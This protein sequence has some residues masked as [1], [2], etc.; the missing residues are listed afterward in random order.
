[1]AGSSSTVEATPKSVAGRWKRAAIVAFGVV[2]ASV[3]LVGVMHMPFARG[4]LMRAGGCPV[5]G[6][7]Q[8]TPEVMEPARHAAMAAERG[9][10]PAPARPCVGFVLD[11]TTRDEVHQWEDRFHVDCEDTNPGLIKCK[12]VAAGALAENDADGPAAE[13]AL[14]FDVQRRLVNVSVF[15][16]HLSDERA[17]S[18][19][20]EVVSKLSPLGAPQKRSGAFDAAH[21]AQEGAAGLATVSYRFSD[22]FAEVTAMRFEGSGL[23]LLEHYMSATD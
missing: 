22:Y 4:L 11:Q 10:D 19:T 23:T 5:V 3:A 15:R 6:A 1:M 7:G 8:A 16:T 13:L 21:F 12:D 14:G 9:H 18:A 20:A 2:A 17:T